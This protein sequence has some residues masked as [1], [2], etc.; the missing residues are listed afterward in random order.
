QDAFTF[1]SP[2]NCKWRLQDGNINQIALDCSIRTINSDVDI[3]K[4]RSD[5]SEQITSINVD[6]SDVLFFQSTLEPR[7]FQRFYHL[8]QLD[9]QFCKLNSLPAGTFLGLDNM[10]SLTVR[11]H[12]TDWSSMALELTPDSLVGMPRLES[13]DL[14]E[15]NLKD[16]PERVFCPL[17]ALLHL[18][19]TANR[20]QDVSEV[21]VVGGCGAHL[22]TLDLTANDLVVLPEAG[23]AGLQSLRELNLQYNKISI[24]HDR[25]LFGLSALN[26]LNISSNH[27]VALPSDAFNET[28]GLQ[29]LYLQNNSLSV[30]AD[31][32]HGLIRLVVLNLS[33]NRLAQVNFDMFRDLSALQVL[34]LSHNSLTVIGDRT[35]SSLANLHRLDLSYNQLLTVQGQSLAGLHVLSAISVAHNNISHISYET[36]ENCTNLSD[37]RLEFNALSEIPSAIVELI[38]LRTLRISHNVLSTIKHDDLTHLTNLIHLDMSNNVLKGICKNCLENLSELKVL[39]LSSNELSAIP[40][41]SFDSNVALQRFSHLQSSISSTI[42][43][44]YCTIGNFLGCQPLIF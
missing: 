19:L 14:G 43:S 28:T 9:I 15:N 22:V 8:Q 10:K 34:D 13:L 4:I 32:F 1:Q 21:G 17:P 38:S 36:F 35:F 23:F 5:Q 7:A 39:D 37:L 30:V 31:T 12:N 16:L 26:I 42:K 33:N 41:V 2:E 25:A 3:F 44:P 20:L 27:I 40:Q 18:N 6:C 24:L 11:T 29:E